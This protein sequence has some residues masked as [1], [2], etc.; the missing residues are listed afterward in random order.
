MIRTITTAMLSIELK[1]RPIRPAAAVKIHDAERSR[2]MTEAGDV[3][4]SQEGR[5]NGIQSGVLRHRVRPR[6]RSTSL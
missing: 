4:T 3:T 6:R 2:K 1:K 5:T